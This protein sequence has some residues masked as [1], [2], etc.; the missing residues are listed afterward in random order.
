MNKFHVEVVGQLSL[1]NSRIE[2]QLQSRPENIETWWFLMNKFHV[3][4]DR[5]DLPVHSW[6]KKTPVTTINPIIIHNRIKFGGF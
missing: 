2:K 1:V 4:V 5:H 6:I 3:D